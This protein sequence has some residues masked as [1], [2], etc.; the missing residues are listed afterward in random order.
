MQSIAKDIQAVFIIDTGSDDGTADA[1]IEGYCNAANTSF[2][3]NG[4]IQT[5]LEPFVDYA[6]SRNR[7][8]ELAA[9]RYETKFLLSLSADE[10]L[11]G[12]AD[13]NAFLDAHRDAPEGAYC[14]M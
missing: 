5:V 10:T 2:G 7:A 6:T 9:E 14:V 8:L 11:V 4:E 12:G 13:L 3:T 1:A